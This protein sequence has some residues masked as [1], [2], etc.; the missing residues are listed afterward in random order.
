MSWG[1]GPWAVRRA[2]GR[3]LSRRPRRSA[4][5]PAAF[6]P[7]VTCPGVSMLRRAPSSALAAWRG[8]VR[9]C[10]RTP[11]RSRRRARRLDEL[12]SERASSA[13]RSSATPPASTTI[14]DRGRPARCR[15]RRSASSSGASRSSVAGR[16]KFD[17]EDFAVERR[18]AQVGGRVEQ[19]QLAV[20]QHADES[21]SAASPTYCVVTSR[22]RPSSRSSGTAPRTS[23]AGSGRCRL[24]ARRGT[25]SS[26]RGRTPRRG[27]GGAASRPTPRAPACRGLAEL[28]PFEHLA[29]RR[30]GAAAGARTSRRG[31]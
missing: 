26:G 8:G 25:R 24:S 10:A 28:D 20:G 17:V 4:A 18:P 6:R 23:P 7:R 5:S 29:Q 13:C 30:F 9:R 3:R 15:R 21:H 2:R 27:R 31:S 19:Q 11:R 22:V 1:H 16:R 12:E 14:T